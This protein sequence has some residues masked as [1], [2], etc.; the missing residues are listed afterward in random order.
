[1]QI[2][3]QSIVYSGHHHIHRYLKARLLI[4]RLQSI[5]H[6]ALLSEMTSVGRIWHA[7]KLVKENIVKGTGY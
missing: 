2:Q 4:L 3:R 7:F 1:M 5:G 6:W